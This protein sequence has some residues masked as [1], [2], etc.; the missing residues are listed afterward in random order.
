M[1]TQM[2]NLTRAALALSIFGLVG[3][4]TMPTLAADTCADKM[5]VVKAEMDKAADA[6]KKAAAEEHYKMAEDA[7]KGKD[8]K[9]CVAHLGMAETALK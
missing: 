6:K 3:T 8:E 9:G 4:A 1:E 5:K 7:M 2:T